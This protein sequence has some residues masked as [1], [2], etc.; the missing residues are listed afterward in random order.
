MVHAWPPRGY[1]WHFS[2][3][4]FSFFID[5]G[6]DFETILAAFW[7][8][9]KP[10]DGPGTSR[11]RAQEAPKKQ[12]GTLLFR[13]WPPRPSKTP[14]KTLQNRILS[15]F[16]G[17]LASSCDKKSTKIWET[18]DTKHLSFFQVP[19]RRP[20]TK[21]PQGLSPYLQSASREPPGKPSRNTRRPKGRLRTLQI[22][23]K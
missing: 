5:F 2:L 18:W 22:N 20:R 6:I 4:P 9:I 16:G 1:S 14:P 10:Q 15:G 12:S 11:W 7:R 17:N 3:A 19:A 23:T 8:K 13:L 21:R